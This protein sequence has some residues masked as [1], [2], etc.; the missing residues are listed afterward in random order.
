MKYHVTVNAVGFRG[1]LETD[2]EGKNEEEVRG[3]ICETIGQL[4][5]NDCDIEIKPKDEVAVIVRMNTGEALGTVYNMANE[6][7]KY[8]TR[9]DS[10]FK[11][12]REALDMLHDFIVNHFGEEEDN[13]YPRPKTRGEL[14]DLL[15]AGKTCEVASQAASTTTIMVNGWLDYADFTVEPSPNIGWSLFVP[16]AD[17]G[18][19][20]YIQVLKQVVC[21]YNPNY[22]DDRICKCGHPYHRHFDSYDDMSASCC[23]Y[24]GCYKFVEAKEDADSTG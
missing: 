18:E 21:K 4:K 24:C 15:K 12:K 16:N 10:S 6:L 19:Q 23:K 5:E 1:T 14:V 8:R 22:G 2:L 7:L 3:F 9:V 20:P 11:K 17:K 13:K